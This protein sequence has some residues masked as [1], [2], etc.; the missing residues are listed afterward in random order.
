MRFKQN[1]CKSARKGTKN[2]NRNRGYLASG[3][4]NQG[5]FQGKCYGCNRVGHMKK[6]C[7]DQRSHRDAEVMFMVNQAGTDG[8]LLDSGASSHMTFTKLDF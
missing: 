8:W 7:P 1:P 3:A 4:R 6:N 5:V 2:A